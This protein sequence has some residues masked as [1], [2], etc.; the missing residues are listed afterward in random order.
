MF[1]VLSGN[2]RLG[3][4]GG[5]GGQDVYTRLPTSYKR[6]THSPLSV[7][8]VSVGCSFHDSYKTGVVIP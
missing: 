2:F 5:G 6:H 8:Q 3:G 1:R 4:G 7:H